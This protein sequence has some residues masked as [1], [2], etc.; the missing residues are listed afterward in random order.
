MEKAE[1]RTSTDAKG[2]E[3]LTPQSDDNLW[4][5]IGDGLLRQNEHRI[6]TIREFVAG[7]IGFSLLIEHSPP[8][9]LA[10]HSSGLSSNHPTSC[11]QEVF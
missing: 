6:S 5:K 4:L 7:T 10:P 9:E 11:A 3:M 2:L 8:W 1:T